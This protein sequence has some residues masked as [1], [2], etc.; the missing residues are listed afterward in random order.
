MSDHIQAVVI[1]AG[2]IGL[3]CARAL[4]RAN[5]EVIIIEREKA[6]ATQTSS[7][8]SEVIHAGIYYPSGSLKATM[9]VSGKHRLYEFCET[10]GVPFKR[11]G[12]LIVATDE[13]EHEA[14]TA[15]REK[16]RINGVEDLKWLSP[17][18]IKA[19][20]PDLSAR[21]ALLSP[22]TGIIDSHAYYLALQGDLE[23]HGGLLA[24]E[25]EIERIDGKKGRFQ[26]TLKGKES[27]DISCDY[28]IN[29]AGL[30]AISLAH[31]I[32]GLDPNVLPKAYFCKG[33]Y[34]SLKGKA[35]FKHL[36]YPV[37]KA[38]GLGVHLTLDLGGQARFG[39]D[40]EWLEG[41]PPF[42]YSVDES[43]GERFYAAIRRYW[44]DLPDNSLHGDYSGIRPKLQA[45]GEEAKDFL[46][47]GP[48]DHGIVG[49]VNLFGIES[50]GLTSSLALADH[51]IM[52]LGIN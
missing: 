16:A 10:F 8:N 12:K 24:L 36:I 30:E 2:V 25:S 18:E 39:P 13:A 28:L 11:C 9:C 41:T 52:K 37:P 45:P 7:R 50:P 26:L 48:G 31:R 17:P 40:I 20:E 21:A 22:S 1:G 27:A 49:L 14:L 23:A 35:P 38:A 33:N 29:A 42:D 32:N 4:A 43:R 5:I 34:F 44:P 51:V 6:I 3:A 19:L 15:I 46:V 47:S